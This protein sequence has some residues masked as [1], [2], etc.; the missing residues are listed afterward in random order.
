MKN[1]KGKGRRMRGQTTLDFAIGISVFL[2]VIVFIFAFAPGILAPFTVTGQSDAITVDRVADQLSQD[3]LGSPEHPYVLDRGCT[4]VFFDRS[5]E[6]SPTFG[7]HDCRFEDA[8]LHAQLGLPE[9]TQVNVT[10]EGNLTDGGTESNQLYWD[11]DE[12]ILENESNANTVK[13]AIGD[14]PRDRQAT[15]SATRVVRLH[16]EDV[17][18]QVV[19]F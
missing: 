9:R 11:T 18:M 2:A 15:T 1:Q 17:T 16:G 10:I 3:L 4:V 13:L 12:R 6:N 8:E 14:E 5:A 7:D 19:V